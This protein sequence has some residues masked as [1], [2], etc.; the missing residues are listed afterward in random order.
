MASMSSSE[1]LSEY[2][3]N[4]LHSNIH[5]L[6]ILNDQIKVQTSHVP[7]L[8]KLSAHLSTLFIRVRIVMID[9]PLDFVIVKFE[10][11]VFP[12]VDG[13]KRLESFRCQ[14]LCPVQSPSWTVFFS[15]YTVHFFFDTQGRDDI[16][17]ESRHL[18]FVA[19]YTSAIGKD[20]K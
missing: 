18:L 7:E 17:M 12:F 3:L 16:A 1:Q 15:V 9:K 4:V 10:E 2:L 6:F 5:Y 20:W 8:C 11:R 13:F 19:F 14:T